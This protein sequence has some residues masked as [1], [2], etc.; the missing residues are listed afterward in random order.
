MSK[1]PKGW[2]IIYTRVNQ[3]KKL[4]AQLNERNIDCYLPTIKVL[5]QWRDRKKLMEKPLFPSYI[6]VYL[7]DI[8]S[9][10]SGLEL[11]SALYY[12]R[13]GK[14][15]TQVSEE[16]VRNIRLSVES[17]NELEVL[18]GHFKRGETICVCEGPL[19]GISGEIVQYHGR[20]NIII[21]VNLL[22]RNLLVTVTSGSAILKSSQSVQ[23]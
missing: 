20:D 18:S 13:S 12:L 15:V 10:Y 21:R 11:D 16:I 8:R 6:F 7:Q 5:S 4:A 19:A 2:Y 17:G 1:F 23:G 14:E 9:Y 22:N 3:E